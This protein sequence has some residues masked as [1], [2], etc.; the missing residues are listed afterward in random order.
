MILLY[1]FAL[2]V[3]SAAEHQW[4]FGGELG[5]G[6]S[7]DPNIS[8]PNASVQSGFRTKATASV[9]WAENP[10]QYLGGEFR[11][12]FRWGGPK[13]AANGTQVSMDGYANVITYDLLIHLTSKESRVRPYF[14][15]GAGIKIYTATGQR[16]PGQPLSDVALLIPG[17]QI[18]PAISAGG[19]LKYFLRPGLQLRVDFRTHMTPLPNDLIRP[20]GKSVIHGWSY[21]FVPMIGVSYAF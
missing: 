8:G 7:H 21:D 13:L 19:G 6:T 15:G 14:A 1:G 3:C 20:V 18:E 16:S 5:L 10:F 4:E 12:M 17:T 9:V 11:Y 2:T